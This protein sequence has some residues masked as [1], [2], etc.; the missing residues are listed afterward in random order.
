M[1][2]PPPYDPDLVAD[3]ILYSATHV[4][5]DWTIGGM[6][7]AQVLFASHFPALFEWLAPLVVPFLSKPGQ[8]KTPGDNLDAPAHDGDERSPDELWHPG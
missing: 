8:R 4:V 3:A 7:R 1:I 2:P 6:G 5:R